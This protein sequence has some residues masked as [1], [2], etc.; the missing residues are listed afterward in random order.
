MPTVIYVCLLFITTAVIIGTVYFVIA[1]I[2]VR[3]T[4]FETEELAKKINADYPLLKLLSMSG[5]IFLSIKN[6]I[7]NISKEE[8]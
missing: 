6:M 7:K 1:M 3:R 4:A 5:S 2:Q 8:E